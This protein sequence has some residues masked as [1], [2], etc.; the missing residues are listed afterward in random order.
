MMPLCLVDSS[1][2]LSIG[3]KKR[4]E[5]HVE[6]HLFDM[7]S[8]EDRYWS[9]TEMVLLHSQLPPDR[10]EQLSRCIYIGIRAH[11]TDYLDIKKAQRMGITVCGIPAVAIN[12]VAEHTFALIFAVAKQALVAHAN[13][14][15]KKWRD[16]LA[17][18]I[19][20][21]GKNLGIIGYGQIGQRVAQIGKS[22]GMKVLV[23]QK[24][25]GANRKFLPLKEVLSLADII[26]LHL[27]DKPQNRL[28]MNAKR[29][30]M[31]KKGAILINT[32]R[33]NILDYDALKAALQQGQL[34]G[35]GVDVYP[36][37][38]PPAE[39]LIRLP[40]VLYSPH[41]A[42]FTRESLAAMNRQL[43]DKAIQFIKKNRRQNSF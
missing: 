35:A 17:P 1:I 39:S 32:A 27:Q 5:N 26:T 38:P 36:Q 12:P 8:R 7:S 3:D 15:E 2:R 14:L 13:V 40:N 10:L 4:L 23:A 28:F 25:G 11:N 34:L 37:E 9:K 6:F 18:N 19:E 42:Y 43:I 20:L 30:A 16:N 33:G 22:L 21:C 41:I 31:L 24:P 29:I